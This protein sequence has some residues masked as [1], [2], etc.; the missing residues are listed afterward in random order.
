MHD[1][2]FIH[3]SLICSVTERELLEE[4]A[5][6]NKGS[7]TRTKTRPTVQQTGTRLLLDSSFLNSLSV[8]D[9]INDTGL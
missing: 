2:N 5:S 9:S 8:N 7:S 3:G 4:L 6:L 1:Q